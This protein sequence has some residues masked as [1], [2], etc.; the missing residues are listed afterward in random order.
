MSDVPESFL[1][2]IFKIY[3]SLLE[4]VI[5]IRS[6]VLD[7]ILIETIFFGGGMMQ[8]DDFISFLNVLNLLQGHHHNFTL[9]LFQPQQVF[10]FC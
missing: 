2:N 3:G 5:N 1:I 6:F 10:Y 4:E 7:E 9:F 8:D